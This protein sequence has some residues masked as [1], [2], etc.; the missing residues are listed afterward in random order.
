MKIFHQSKS[1][2]KLNLLYYNVNLLYN[3]TN[4][5]LYPPLRCL[6]IV[7]VLQPEELWPKIYPPNMWILVAIGADTDA[8][9]DIPRPRGIS[10]GG[11]VLSRVVIMIPERYLWT[12]YY[13]DKQYLEHSRILAV[14][15]SYEKL[16]WN[17]SVKYC[18]CIHIFMFPKGCQPYSIYPCGKGRQA[19]IDPDPDTP[20]CIIKSCS[21]TN[22]PKDYKSDL[23]YGKKST[24]VIIL[25]L[26][27]S[28]RHK[29]YIRIIIMYVSQWGVHLTEFRRRNHEGNISERSRSRNFL[30][31]HRLHVLQKR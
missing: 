1:V 29:N 30:R 6:A 18:W 25:F 20:E 2:Q 17:I 12:T 22:Y 16:L 28:S 27:C 7:C 8:M 19:C 14:A 10:L 13:N 3:V 31:L 4:F 5:R 15:N 11:M 9:A 21:N 24:R 26:N 23:Y